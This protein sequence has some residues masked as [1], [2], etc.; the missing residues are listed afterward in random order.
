M[1]RAAIAAVAL[2]AIVGMIGNSHR[3]PAAHHGPSDTTVASSLRRHMS[4]NFGQVA[5]YPLITH[6]AS[7]GGDVS[8]ETS[9]YSKDSNQVTAREM[10]T[11]ARFSGVRGVT[12]VV[13]HGS[14]GG[15]LVRCMP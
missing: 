3:K 14:D 6:V 15:V 13:V 4:E 8:L 7:Y 5:W 1:K 9:M 10:C 11:A 2:L 12:G